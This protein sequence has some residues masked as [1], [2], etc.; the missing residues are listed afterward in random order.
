MTYP[1]W[2]EARDLTRWTRYRMGCQN[3]LDDGWDDYY[4][5]N[6]IEATLAIS[7]RPD[8]QVDTARVKFDRG[9]KAWYYRSCVEFDEDDDPDYHCTHDGEHQL[10]P[11]SRDVWYGGWGME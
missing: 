7:Y 1:T 10:H 8:G 9:S 4:H 2:D 3:D 6:G 11:C 5:G